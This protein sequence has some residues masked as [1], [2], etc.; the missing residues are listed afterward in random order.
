ME[1]IDLNDPIVKAE[2]ERVQKETEQKVRDEEAA[3]KAG[4]VDEIKE[5][6]K[7]KGLDENG[8]PL[9]VPATPDAIEEKVKEILQKDRQKEAEA[10]RGK[11]LNKFFEQNKEFHPE[12]DPAGLKFRLIE[13][14]LNNFKQ[15]NLYSETDFLTLFN[16]ARN[17]AMANDEAD[18]GT[19]LK[20][21]GSTPAGGGAGKPRATNQSQ[22]SPAER[23]LIDQQGW[24]EDRYLRLK[25][26]PGMAD[27]ISRLLSAVPQ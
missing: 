21:D 17:L 19:S 14:E 9:Q 10:N 2:I 5:L 16:K 24:T 20:D 8:Q 23:K 4:L 26:K 13:D 1:D 12:N 3:T 25:A 6:R 11:A 18:G 27:Y 22:L 7:K 15:D